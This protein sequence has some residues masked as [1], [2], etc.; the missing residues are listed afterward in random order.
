MCLL[1]DK[2]TLPEGPGSG[3]VWPAGKGGSRDT[4]CCARYMLRM[5]YRDSRKSRKI[6]LQKA[7]NKPPNET[8][9]IRKNNRKCI[10]HRCG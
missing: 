9:T 7:D 5:I 4:Y 8:I 1:V 6:G 2:N 3:I 10:V